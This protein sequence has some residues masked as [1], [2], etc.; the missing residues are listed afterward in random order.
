MLQRTIHAVAANNAN[1]TGL[2]LSDLGRSTPNVLVVPYTYVPSIQ[3]NFTFN[4]KLIL[5][6]T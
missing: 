1:N 6:L 3:T 2:L 5:S 4:D